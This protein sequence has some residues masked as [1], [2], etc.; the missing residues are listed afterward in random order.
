MTSQKPIVAN[1]TDQSLKACYFP[2]LTRPEE[3]K[4]YRAQ[5]EWYLAPLKGTLSVQFPK[6][7]DSAL[8]QS[9]DADIVLFW[10]KAAFWEAPASLRRKGVIVDEYAQQAVGDSLDRFT[11]DKAALDIT[12]ESE[13]FF[14]TI[15]AQHPDI[16]SVIIVGSGPNI[17]A[18][19]EA[20]KAALK[21]AVSVYLSTSILHESICEICPPNI[22]IAVDGPSQFGPSETA[23]R[24]RTRAVQL[25]RK[26]KSLILVPAQHLPS[27]RAHW[28]DDIQPYVF[29]VPMVRQTEAG[30]KL[31]GDWHYQPTSNVLTSFGLPCA[32]SLS[33]KIYLAGISLK[34]AEDTTQIHWQHEGEAQYQR[35]IAPM[36]A[37]HPASG[38]DT[39]HY[40]EQ[41]HAR[42]KAELSAYNS[43]G[44]SFTT[45]E[46]G[47]I[48]IA[49]AP[50]PNNPLKTN[51]L[52]VKIFE[53]IARAE[54]Y[55]NR[56][57]GTT[58]I[59]AG[60]LGAA[61]QYSIGLH[62]TGFL[63]AGALAAFLMA[64]LL[65]LRLRMNRMQARLETKLSQQQAQ[66]FA[67][68]SERLEALEPKK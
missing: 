16:P 24:Y 64:G 57:I 54:H 28:P 35:H 4:A 63:I 39:A 60:L 3:M 19:K 2:A 56:I 65:F 46:T 55:P 45:F 29:A 20:P 59:L 37:R 9:R 67:N 34:P 40:V 22:I 38:Q 23:Q 68:L 7:N 62:M 58:F 52:K 6:D 18:L 26:H 41:H 27:I 25:I 48:S 17:N 10:Q 5:A 49:Q 43:A 51:P 1:T 12:T 66:Q 8:K 44:V 31:L 53:A 47:D 11:A 33:D 42:L 36:L 21:N 15:K 61:L 32:A 14:E 30:H 13:R 50:S